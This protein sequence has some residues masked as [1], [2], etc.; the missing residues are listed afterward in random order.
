[1]STDPFGNGE[2]KY[3][4]KSENLE[5]L[6]TCYTMILEFLRS[7]EISQKIKQK[8]VKNPHGILYSLRTEDTLYGIKRKKISTKRVKK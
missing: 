3:L 5:L 1:M 6:S 8:R 7:H 2:R 4:K